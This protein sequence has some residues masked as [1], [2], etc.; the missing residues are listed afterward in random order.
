[1]VMGKYSMM[2]RSHTRKMANIFPIQLAPRQPVYPPN[3]P[4]NSVSSSTTPKRNCGSYSRASTGTVT[5]K[6]TKAN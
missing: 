2:V 4:Q 1:M 5:E 6:S 3:D